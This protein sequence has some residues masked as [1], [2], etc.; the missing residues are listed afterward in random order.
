MV[1]LHLGGVGTQPLLFSRGK[2]SF[3]DDISE[4]A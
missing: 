4:G 1:S 2:C 3:V